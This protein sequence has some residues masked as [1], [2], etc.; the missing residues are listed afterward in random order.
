MDKK[1][2]SKVVTRAII[3]VDGKVLLGKRARGRGSNQ[4]ALV[5][6][7]PEGNETPEDA[8]IREVQEELGIL[9]K[10]IKPWK[11]EIDKKSVP[12]EIWS[13]YYFYGKAEGEL[14][15]KKDEILDTILVGKENLPGL[16]IAFDHRNI[17]NEFFGDTLVS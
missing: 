2:P 4:Y 10:D 5:G 12:G 1:I 6:G 8:I 16:D 13:V 17:L 15:L 14:N 9:F 7:K 3:L 11:E